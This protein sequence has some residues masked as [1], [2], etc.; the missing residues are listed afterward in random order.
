MAWFD[1]QKRQ[2][3]EERRKRVQPNSIAELHRTFRHWLCLEDT[4][5][6]DV[7]LASVLDRKVSGDPVWLMLVAAS[8]G[9]KTEILRSVLSLPYVLEI[10]N[11]TSRSI[12]T[13]RVKPNSTENVTGLAK[14]ANGKV[15][16]F[17]DFTE[18]LSKNQ[19]ERQEI[20][21]QFRTWYDGHVSR[22]FGSTDRIVTVDSTIGLIAGVTPAIDLFTSVLGVL[23]ERFLKFRH[24][25]DREK[26]RNKSRENAGREEY[27]R[28]EL[29][30]AVSHHLNK[31]IDL[32][33][34]PNV[35]TVIGD[36]IGCLAELTALARASVPRSIGEGGAECAIEPEYS[37]RIYKQLL[38]LAQ[39]L[40]IVRQLTVVGKAELRTISRIAIDSCVPHRIDV[41]KALYGRVLTGY[42]VAQMTG[43]PRPN[44]Y[45]GLEN[46]EALGF[47]TV[48]DDQPTSYRLTPLIT[49][50]L[51]AVFQ[52]TPKGDLGGLFPI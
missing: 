20:I 1:T 35:P 32:T 17:K 2:Y 12:I 27:M 16:V 8:G 7:V 28:A 24:F 23:G 21:G 46:L 51:E 29:R 6:I 33:W 48:S 41:L 40:A 15:L 26:A 10:D 44:V 22:R 14:E 39:M 36:R 5:L 49:K 47:V 45:R 42:E 38:K 13:G 3:E 30:E 19:W 4:D 34:V 11:L 25:Q 18:L 31:N 52:K 9:L 50:G 37:T 43:I